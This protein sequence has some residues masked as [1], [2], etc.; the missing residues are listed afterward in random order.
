MKTLNNFVWVPTTKDMLEEKQ[1][2]EKKLESLDQK[3]I[4]ELTRKAVKA[5]E[6]SYSPY[7]N[8]KVGVTLLCISGMIY[9]SC[10]A[11]VAS[12]S[13]TDH[14]E[15][16]VIT[17]AISEGEAIKSGRRFI[18]AIVVSHKS[19]SGPFGRCRQIMAEHCDNALIIDIDLHGNIKK[20]TSLKTLFPY[21]FTPTQLGFS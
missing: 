4:D 11:E 19:E 14:G 7:S 5:S 10:N 6:N 18:E 3:T 1:W 8:Y 2:I 21:S 20:I 16:S 9:A 12:Y 15:E 13:E 17:K